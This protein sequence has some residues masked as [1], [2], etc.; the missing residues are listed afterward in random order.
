MGQMKRMTLP[1]LAVLLSVGIGKVFEDQVRDSCVA[2]LALPG[3]TPL[4]CTQRLGHFCSNKTFAAAVD[5]GDAD[6]HGAIRHNRLAFSCNR[7]HNPPPWNGR[8]VAVRFTDSL[9]RS[10]L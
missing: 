8:R 1:A 9:V 2:A 3:A 6:E 10:L 5:P 4:L 7:L